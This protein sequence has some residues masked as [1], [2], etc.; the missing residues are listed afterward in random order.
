MAPLDERWAELV[1]LT[2]DQGEEPPM[3]NPDLADEYQPKVEKPTEA[4]NKEQL[5]SEAAEALRSTMQTIQL[6]PE[7][8][9]LVIEL[10]GSSPA[11]CR[12]VKK[13]PPPFWA[14][15]STINA[16]CGGRI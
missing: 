1:E 7:D 11:F 15:G 5:R 2:R 6:L 12:S 16:G 10:V 4:L 8:G 3:P 14:R 9:Q 13:R